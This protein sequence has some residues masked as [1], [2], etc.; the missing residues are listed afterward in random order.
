[1]ADELTAGSVPRRHPSRRYDEDDLYQP[2]SRFERI[3]GRFGV[4][5]AMLFFIGMGVWFGGS[6]FANHVAMPLVDRHIKFLDAS[7][8][9][10]KATAEVVKIQVDATN[11]V[12]D[13]LKG[14]ENRQ[15][16][17]HDLLGKFVTEQSKTNQLIERLI[18]NSKKEEDPQ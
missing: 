10:M 15:N 18:G 8:S 14:I 6:W 12:A 3:A 13:G 9:T 16:E 7:E 2:A 1:M 17:T 4:P 5:V 11:K